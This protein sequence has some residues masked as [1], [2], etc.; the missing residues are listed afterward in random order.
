VEDGRDGNTDGTHDRSGWYPDPEQTER[1]VGATLKDRQFGPKARG[2]PDL[3]G[4]S[5]RLCYR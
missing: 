1:Q 5:A 4:S 2:T 3:S